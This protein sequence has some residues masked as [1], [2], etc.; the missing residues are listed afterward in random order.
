MTLSGMTTHVH[1]LLAAGYRSTKLIWAAIVVVAAL[2]V[3][4]TV[5]ALGSRTG[6]ASPAAPPTVATQPTSHS[7]VTDDCGPSRI[8]HPC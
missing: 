4:A 2:A 5:L 3:T 1:D 7:Q 6:D 8:V